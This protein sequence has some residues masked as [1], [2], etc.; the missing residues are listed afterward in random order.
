MENLQIA[1]DRIKIASKRRSTSLDLSGLELTELPEEIGKLENLFLLNISENKLTK[2]GSEIGNLKFL[3]NLD[4][5][6]NKLNAIPD[7]ISHLKTILKLDLRNNNLT[8]LPISIGHLTSLQELYLSYNNITEIPDEIENLVNLK[9]LYITSNPLNKIPISICKLKQ[10]TDLGLSNIN[11]K[12]I[13]KEINLMKN[14]EYIDLSYNEIKELPY[15]IT[16]LVKLNQI[17]IDFNPINNPPIDTIKQ[18]VKM[19]KDWFDNNEQATIITSNFQVVN[20]NIKGVLKVSNLAKILSDIIEEIK[21][22]RGLMV[23]IF[24]RWGRGKTFLWKHIWDEIRTENKYHKVEFHAWKYQETPASWA[25]LYETFAKVF[26]D[27]PERWWQLLSWLKFGIKLFAFNI[28]RKGILP[29]LKFLFAIGIGIFVIFISEIAKDTKIAKTVITEYEN[30]YFLGQITLTLGLFAGF[31]SSFKKEYGTKATDLFKK[32]TAKHSYSELLGLQAEIEKEL[33]ELLV[34]WSRRS[35]KFKKIKSLLKL[36]RKIILFVDDIDRC[37]DDR[38]IQVVDAIKVLLENKKISERLIVLTAIDERILK[39]AIAVKYQNFLKDKEDKDI[40]L[41]E[42]IREYMDK[43]FLL[44]IKLGKLNYD[45]KIQ[46]FENYT[47][48]KIKLLAKEK[49]IE[50]KIE[51]KNVSNIT[52]KTENKEIQLS[53]LREDEKIIDALDKREKI[54]E[55]I[56]KNDK[57]IAV[58]K[59]EITSREKE[60]IIN[61]LNSDIELT[62]RTIRIFYNRYLLAKNLLLNLKLNKQE[63]QEWVDI[64]EKESILASLIQEYSFNSN[65]EMLNDLLID[66]KNEKEDKTD[67]NIKGKDYAINRNLLTK[68]LETIEMIVPY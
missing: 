19:I 40:K 52:L 62:P 24:G 9:S 65:I 2:I 33:E 39:R 14:L 30:F 16:E 43:L 50:K 29:I 27:K 55:I 23:G 37:S 42:L 25:Y 51:L 56:N 63:S 64:E 68:I 6:Y 18:G 47:E 61:I 12:S 10:L 44:G 3:Q 35:D 13:P 58:E 66:I 11:L 59:H 49:D 17:I 38:I 48:G 20:E 7:E 34:F 1:I 21:D 5:R 41:Q 67:F 60:S 32:Y 36:D 54:G 28:K 4:V 53:E 22:E 26:Y 45:E 8:T 46:I 15:E 57:D 31:I